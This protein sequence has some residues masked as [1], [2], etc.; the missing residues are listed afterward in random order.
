MNEC[1]EVVAGSHSA[2]IPKY[3]FWL[4]VNLMVRVAELWKRK[5][6]LVVEEKPASD[7]EKHLY[8]CII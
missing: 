2:D 5:Y 7:M 3:H 4:L 6:T 8:L 1:W